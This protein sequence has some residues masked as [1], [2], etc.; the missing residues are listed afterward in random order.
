MLREVP[1][2]NNGFEFLE[3]HRASPG[4]AV[5]NRG[6]SSPVRTIQTVTTSARPPEG[7][8]KDTTDLYFCP[9]GL[10]LE[11]GLEAAD[12]APAREGSANLGTID[13]GV[14]GSR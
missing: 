5:T 3:A 4:N 8:S 13:D 9:N 2:Q 12:R 10:F 11:D 6:D 14:V 7:P 1:I